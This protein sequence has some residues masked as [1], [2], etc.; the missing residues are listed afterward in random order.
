MDPEKVRDPSTREHKMYRLAKNLNIIKEERLTEADF[1]QGP[2]AS[3]IPNQVNNTVHK[4]L[5]PWEVF[6]NVPRFRYFFTSALSKV[7]R[8]WD[9]TTD[10]IMKNDNPI[11]KSLS[12][13]LH[14]NAYKIPASIGNFIA[15]FI[16]EWG[17]NYRSKVPNYPKTLVH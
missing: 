6:K 13:Q 4:S 2:I 5:T 10:H 3:D 9:P 11:S 7:W 17:A 1:P 15:Y 14:K 12:Y 8:T 16:N